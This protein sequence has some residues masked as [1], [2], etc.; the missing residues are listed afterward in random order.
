MNSFTYIIED[1]EYTR[2]AKNSWTKV[3]WFAGEYALVRQVP[4]KDVA[5]LESIYQKSLIA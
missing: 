3:Y 4:L 1:Y 2:V 5:Q